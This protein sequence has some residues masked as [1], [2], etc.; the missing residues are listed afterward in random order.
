LMDTRARRQAARIV[1]ETTPVWD[2]AIIL[3]TVRVRVEAPTREQAKESALALVPEDYAEA[4]IR[5]LQ[6]TRPK[7][8]DVIGIQ[9]PQRAEHV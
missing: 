1:A 9:R 8:G 4:L 7:P 6:Y 2:V 5:R 3:P